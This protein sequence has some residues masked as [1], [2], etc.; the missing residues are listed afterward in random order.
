MV[1]WRGR[2]IGGKKGVRVMS[3]YFFLHME[4]RYHSNNS[5]M[6]ME[7]AYSIMDLLRFLEVFLVYYDRCI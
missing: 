4:I 6:P 3:T 7:C 5:S 2:E 1:M